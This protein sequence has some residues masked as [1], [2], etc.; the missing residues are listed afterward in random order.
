QFPFLSALAS[1]SNPQWCIEVDSSTEALMQQ[2]VC[3]G[4]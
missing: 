4:I 2:P 3:Q 1:S